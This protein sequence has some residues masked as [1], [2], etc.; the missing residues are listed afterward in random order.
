M[1]ESFA[2]SRQ[3]TTKTSIDVDTLAM[4]L[5]ARVCVS[6]CLFVARALPCAEDAGGPLRWLAH[7]RC[8]RRLTEG[9]IKSRQQTDRPT[10]SHPNILAIIPVAIHHQHVVELRCHHPSSYYQLIIIQIDGSDVSTSF[11]EQLR[12]YQTVH[13][14]FET[15]KQ[16][17]K[18]PALCFVSKFTCE[19][20]LYKDKTK[21]CF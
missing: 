3:R 8:I 18:L 9:A 13:L 16:L 1:G 7:E 15:V 10:D 12:F 6:A 4:C 2:R 14:N 20:F 17:Y 11:I 5:L 19:Q 21:R